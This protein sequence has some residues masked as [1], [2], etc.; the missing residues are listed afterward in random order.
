MAEVHDLSTDVR[1]VEEIRGGASDAE[2]ALYEKFSARVYYLA[3][4]ELRSPA[5]AEDARAETFL[6]VLQAVRGDAL[7]SPQALSSFVLST[8]RNV[9]REQH[10]QNRRTEQIDEVELDRDDKFARHQA[11]S[12]PAVK[13]AIERAIKRLK[14]REQQFLRMYY[15]EETSPDE[16]ARVLGIKPER[17]RLIKSRALKSFREQYERLTKSGYKQ[18]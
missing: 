7:Q 11:F 8:T 13:T 17:V 14:P 6:R 5:D 1:L 15:Y 4:R 9:I 16:I 18:A 10:R 3:L 2:S 12:D